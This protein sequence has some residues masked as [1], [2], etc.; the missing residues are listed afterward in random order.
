LWFGFG[1]GCGGRYWQVPGA[2]VE[3]EQAKP[4]A[5]SASEVHVVLHPGWA[6]VGSQAKGEQ[7]VVEGWHWPAAQVEVVRLIPSGQLGAAQVLPAA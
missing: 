3:P 6:G 5:Q 2:A 4:V 1:P 7:L